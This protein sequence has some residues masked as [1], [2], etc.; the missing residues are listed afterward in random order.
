MFTLVTFVL[1]LTFFYFKPETLRIH[2]W[3]YN[4]SVKYFNFQIFFSKGDIKQITLAR[5]F[6]LLLTHAATNPIYEII[7]VFVPYIRKL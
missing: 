7:S 2:D 5:G 6:M 1:V 4:W 3:I